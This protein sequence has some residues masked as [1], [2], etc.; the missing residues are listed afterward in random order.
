[1]RAARYFTLEDDGLAQQWKAST[2]FMN[3]PFGSQ[4]AKFVAKFVKSYELGYIKSG[5]ILVSAHATDTT[6]FQ[7]LWGGWLCFTRGRDVYY[8]I[9]GE[10]S[11]TFGSVFIY[12]GDEKEKFKAEFSKYGHVVKSA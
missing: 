10:S 5:I 6:W 1:M 2:V 12:F 8:Q 9:D 4:A 7:H 11:P 3:P